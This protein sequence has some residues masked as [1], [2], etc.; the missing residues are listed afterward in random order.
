M[1][2]LLEKSEEGFLSSH[3]DTE[4][5]CKNKGGVKKGEEDLFFRASNPTG[6]K[7]EWFRISEV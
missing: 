4:G 6:T 5:S 1:N 3:N 2:I 7:P